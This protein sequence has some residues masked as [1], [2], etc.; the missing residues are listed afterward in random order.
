MRL[1]LFLKKVRLIKRRA[2]AKQLIERGLVK[3]KGEK[4]KPSKDV[5]PGMKINLGDITYEI[6]A[7]PDKEIIKNEGVK[8][9]KVIEDDW[10]NSG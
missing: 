10:D 5:Y 1:D 3:I 8:Y 2:I 4:T 9:Y 6:T 7:I